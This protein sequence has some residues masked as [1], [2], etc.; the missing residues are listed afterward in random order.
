MPPPPLEVSSV[1][2]KVWSVTPSGREGEWKG[3]GRETIPPPLRNERGGRAGKRCL[4]VRKRKV[5][6]RRRGGWM[7][8]CV[9]VCVSV[10]DRGGGRA[11]EESNASEGFAALARLGCSLLSLCVIRKKKTQRV[12]AG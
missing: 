11:V 4:Y 9:C 8:V 5:F 12:G 3:G 7:R 6:L 2:E 1:P 10:R